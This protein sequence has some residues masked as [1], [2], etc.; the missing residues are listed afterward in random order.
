M[1]TAVADTATT[2]APET[3]SPASTSSAPVTST[4]QTTASAPAAERLTPNA[5][6]QEISSFLRKLD[7]PAAATPAPTIAAQP[8]G[9]TAQAAADPP[10]AGEVPKPYSAPPEKEWP[11]ILENARTK[12]IDGFRA[13]Y[14]ITPQVTPELFST[15]I[16]FARAINTNPIQFLNEL[17][18]NIANHPVWGPQLRSSAGRTL[19]S[20]PASRPEPD[21]QI[22]NAQGQVVGM[23]YS[24][25]RLQQAQEWDWTQREQKLNQRIQPLVSAEEKRQ[26]DA[27]E[28]AFQKDADAGAETELVRVNEI[29]EGKTELGP[30]VAKL[31][32]QGVN[33]IDAAL[34]VR[35]QFIAP[36]ITAA[37]EAA[38]LDTQRKKAAGNTVNGSGPT[39][40]TRK[41]HPGMT[42]KEFAAALRE[43][44]QA[45]A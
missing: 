6:Q 43:A 11:T 25:E 23:T 39:T 12:A 34:Q 14:G 15:G 2:P 19:A 8:G 32:A 18:A 38:V 30:E 26:S 7:A 42:Q 33:H 5:T 21:V 31:M 22:M 1:D 28:A 10:K 27:Q 44:D 36:T 24:A 40:T 20:P 3:S 29:L 17:S 37:A 9:P 41:F 45:S 35:K 13:Q 16:G 4:A